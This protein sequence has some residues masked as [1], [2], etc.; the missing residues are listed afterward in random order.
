MSQFAACYSM[1]WSTSP[2]SK[3]YTTVIV[4]VA[5]ISIS[6]HSHFINIYKY[7]S[8]HYLIIWN[9][10]S[11]FF[12]IYKSISPC[13]TNRTCWIRSDQHDAHKLRDLCK[14]YL[15]NFER[16]ARGLFL[17]SLTDWTCIHGNMVEWEWVRWMYFNFISLYFIS[18]WPCS[19]ASQTPWGLDLT[20]CE[21]AEGSRGFLEWFGPQYAS[22]PE[23]GR[24]MVIETSEIWFICTVQCITLPKYRYRIH[25]IN[26]MWYDSWCND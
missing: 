24:G 13:L 15:F 19:S 23:V 5:N 7:K 8:N 10:E 14:R 9:L 3:E 4:T 16:R 11:Y 26:Y 18:Y 2:V 20:D 12:I 22:R 25:I 17:T 1:C 6:Y 21:K